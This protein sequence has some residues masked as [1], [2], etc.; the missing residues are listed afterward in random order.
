MSQMTQIVDIQKEYSTTRPVHCLKERQKSVEY[1]ESENN[2]G[3][4]SEND[5]G[6]S[7]LAMF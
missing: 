4:Q 1:L 5:L 7:S 6:L 3:L 2:L